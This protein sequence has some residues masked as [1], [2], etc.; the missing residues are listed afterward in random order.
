MGGEAWGKSLGM[1]LEEK[2][3]GTSLPYSTIQ[4][5]QEQPRKKKKPKAVKY[6]GGGEVRVGMTEVNDSNFVMASLRVHESQ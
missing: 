2:R 5:I 6:K 3:G 1:K 4:S